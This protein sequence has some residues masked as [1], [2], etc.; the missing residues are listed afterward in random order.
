MAPCLICYFIVILFKWL[1]MRNLATIF[2]LKSILSGKFQCFKNAVLGRQE[3]VQCKCYFWHQT[4]PLLESQ[5][6]FW[7]R[8]DSILF[9]VSS[10]LKFVKWV[11]IFKRNCALKSA[12][13]FASFCW[14]WDFL[15]EN[16]ELKKL[17]WCPLERVDKY[18]KVV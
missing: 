15:L 11:R 4:E 5:K 7:L 18:K 14:S 16:V 2:P 8:C 17:W 1:F 9:S 12:I 13:F 10:K 6:G 3:M